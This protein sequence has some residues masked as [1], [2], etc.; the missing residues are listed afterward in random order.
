MHVPLGSPCRV[1][2]MPQALVILKQ[3]HFPN[4][5]HCKYW[6][7]SSCGVSRGAYKSVTLQQRHLF[8]QAE[9]KCIGYSHISWHARHEVN[10]P[11]IGSVITLTAPSPRK[12]SCTHV[13]RD[14]ASQDTLIN[15]QRPHRIAK[16]LSV[17]H[18]EVR[19]NQ[20]YCLYTHAICPDRR[21]DT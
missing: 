7:H 10:L 3:W 20:E 16:S 19:T 2:A 17:A 1:E 4:H 9:L 21:A 14:N 15:L 13:C 8:G 6:N 5:S 11:S 18:Q 12:R